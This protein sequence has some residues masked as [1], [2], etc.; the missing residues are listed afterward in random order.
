M[1][2]QNNIKGAKNSRHYITV[3]LT[4]ILSLFCIVVSAEEKMLIPIGKTVGITVRLSGVYIVNTTEFE[5]ADGELCSPAS[6][7]GILV[8]DIITSVD[9]QEIHSAEDL[10]R[11]T[12]NSNGEEMTLKISRKGSNNDEEVK[13]S[14]VKNKDDNKYRIGVWAKDSASGIGAMTYLNP[15][16]NEFAALGHGICDADNTLSEIIGGDIFDSEITS[17]RRGEKGMP[18][19]IMAIFEDDDKSI[20]N[21][22]DNCECGV[23]GIMTDDVSLSQQK[24]PVAERSEL[25][26]GEAVVISDVCGGEAEE[27]SVEIVKVNKD[28][29]SPKSM[30]VKITD[31]RLLEKTGGIVRG[32]SGSPIIK[33]GKIIG[34][35]THVLVNDSTRGYGIFIEN[36]LNASNM[37]MSKAV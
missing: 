22:T 33:D 26:E 24:I 31:E 6:D 28:V 27:Y 23:F 29:T 10:E 25:S 7:A 3:I 21:I 11:A 14:A 20:A 15:E 18:G 5:N 13:L 2:S 8:G 19:E 32:M 12:D 1:K 9:G 30:I 34:A 4:I 35:I 37:P 17:I 36:M 16:T